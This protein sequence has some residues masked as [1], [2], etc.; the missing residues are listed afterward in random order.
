MLAGNV[1][2]A[3]YS[4]INAM[5]VGK[6]LGEAALAA[7]T[8][9]IPLVFV[10]M[11]LAS[12]LTMATNILISQHYGAKRDH[13][14][15]RVVQSSVL[16]IGVLSLLLFAA[17]EYFAPHLLRLMSTPPAVLGLATGYLR[18]YLFS[19]PFAFGVYLISAMLRGIG[20]STTPLYFQ[21]ASVVV[22]AILDPLLMF[23]WLG[24]PRLG[25]NGT[26]WSAVI[27]QAAAVLAIFIYLGRKRSPVSPDW[28]RLRFDGETTLRTLKIGFPSAI[29]QSLVSIGLLF[30]ISL[31]NGFG[32][33]ATAAYG[34]AS[35]I[36]QLA[37]LPAQ[38]FGMA[39][40]TLSGQN[41]GARK[42]HRVTQTFKWGVLLS[43][44]VTLMAS[45]LALFMPQE[46]L[47]AFTNDQAVIHTGA[48]YL[49]TVGLAYALFAISF[50]CNGVI[51]GAGQTLMTTLFSLISLWV[52]RVPV[53]YYLSHRLHAVRG[54]WYGMA[55]SYTISMLV[56]LLYYF[57]G[58]WRKGIAGKEEPVLLP[59]EIEKAAA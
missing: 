38:T 51:N 46:L 12:G 15:R 13:Q 18:I 34:A 33:N 17:G 30:V 37:F 1:L 50:A 7:V 2:V 28:R 16:L 39:I 9:S 44:G 43:V 58:R 53:A 59:L 26:G 48:V 36:D 10:F 45:A 11:A 55:I 35:R 52:V 27:T 6:F 19:L 32:E 24:M 47:R 22:L 40:S 20:D 3:A 54:V 42:Y 31:V 21:T 25:L 14:L 29:Q 57:S 8:V 4:F 23:G 56:S 41:I 49:R 5:W